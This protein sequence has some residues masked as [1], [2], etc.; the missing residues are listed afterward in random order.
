MNNEFRSRQIYL[1][2]K[3]SVF[4]IEFHLPEEAIVTLSILSQEGKII[5]QVIDKRK[6][7]SGR[8]EIDFDRAKCNGDLCF[9]RLSMR[10]DRQ[11]IVDTKKIFSNTEG[12]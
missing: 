4:T 10:I 5:E 12:L 7:G 3:S 8:H 1:E 6:F 11:E 2:I 9:Y